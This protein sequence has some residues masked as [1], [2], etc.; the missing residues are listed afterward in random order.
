MATRGVA[1]VIEVESEPAAVK[2][3]HDPQLEKAVEVLM[4]ELKKTPP[5]VYKR[6][7]FPNNHKGGGAVTTGTR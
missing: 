6:P 2:A 5:P 1:P 7:D 3:G 4:A